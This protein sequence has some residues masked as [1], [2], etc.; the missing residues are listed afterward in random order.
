MRALGDG[1][2]ALVLDARGRGLSDRAPD[3]DYSLG[4]YVADAAAVIRA[5]GLER[6]AVLG[7]SMGARVAAALAAAQPGLAGPVVLVDPPLSGPGRGPYPTTRDAFLAQLHE[8]Q[9]GTDAA[10]VARHYPGWSERE[11]ALRA[12][13]LPT[14]DEQAVVASHAGFESEDFFAFWPR[15]PGSPGF[16]HGADSPVVTAEGAREAREA[17]PA[18]RFAAVPR[19]GHMV[20]WDNLDGF[21][22]AVRPMLAMSPATP[23]TSTRENR[24]R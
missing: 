1:V 3:G 18:A 17:L 13:W 8:A 6:P 14:C 23:S 22:A 11:R 19:A 7:H 15:V 16:V 12:R 9:A 20:P 5:L 21:L 2:R 10:G 4:A 24:G